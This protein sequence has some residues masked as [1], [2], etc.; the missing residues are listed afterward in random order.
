MRI[1]AAD[2]AMCMLVA[3]GILKICEREDVLLL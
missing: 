2:D 3:S 1:S